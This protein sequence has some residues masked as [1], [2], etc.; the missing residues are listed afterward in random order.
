[1]SVR[2]PTDG[3][4]VDDGSRPS[5]HHCPHSLLSLPSIRHH[6]RQEGRGDL[7]DGETK[8]SQALITVDMLALLQDA[9]FV[10]VGSMMMALAVEESGLQ[11]RIALRILLLMGSNPRWYL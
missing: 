8:L 1:M 3:N 4:V 7:S 5:G 6:R 2:Y 9:N 11:E 10:F